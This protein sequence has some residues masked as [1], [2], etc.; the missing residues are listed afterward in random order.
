M[1]GLSLD[2]RSADDDFGRTAVGAV[3]ALDHEVDQVLL[4][5]GVEEAGVER[6]EVGLALGNLDDPGAAVAR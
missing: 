1:D 5:H 4:V 2:Q 6:T 3:A